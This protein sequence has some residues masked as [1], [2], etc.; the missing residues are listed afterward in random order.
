MTDDPIV[1]EVRRWRE[2][3]AA[4][5]NFDLGA[6]FDDLRRGTEEAQKAGRAVITLPPRPVPPLASPVHPNRPE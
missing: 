2:Q 5:F 4:Q 6:I 3:Y 1:Q